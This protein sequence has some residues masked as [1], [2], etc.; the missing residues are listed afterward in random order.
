MA[1]QSAKVVSVVREADLQAAVISLA[2]SFGYRVTH[3]RPAR[4]IDGGW[5]TALQGDEGFPDC[6]LAKPG[7]AIAAEL[8]SERGQLRP[9]QA[10]W[11][12]TL[13]AAGI[14]VYVWRPT[15]WQSGAIEAA[16]AG[17]GSR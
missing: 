8:K 16:L 13:A 7:R 5:R 10:A 12:K 1:H 15:D 11:L 3:F 4:T 17:T 9:A 6:F 14:E 2:H